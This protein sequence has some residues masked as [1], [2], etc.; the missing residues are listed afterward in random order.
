ML[1][2]VTLGLL[3]ATP[4]WAE[5][6]DRLPD[7]R[8]ER[9]IPFD[10]DPE[11]GDM[12]APSGLSYPDVKAAL[13]EVIQTALYCGQPD[14]M[15][16]VHLTFDLDVGC[17]GVVKSVRTVDAGGAPDAYVQCVSA[18][19]KKADFPAHDMEGGYPVTYP[20]NVSW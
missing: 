14:G 7:P 10:P 15:N 19:I 4:C 11:E 1:L 9:C 2:P 3:W 8:P 17:D 6:A 5:P 12:V 18:V 20:V 13:N 16:A